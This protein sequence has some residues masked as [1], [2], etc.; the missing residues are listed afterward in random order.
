MNSLHCF[1]VSTGLRPERTH[2]LYK[3]FYFSEQDK[4]NFW[5]SVSG[6]YGVELLSQIKMKTI[7]KLTRGEQENGWGVD[8]IG[9]GSCSTLGRV[10]AM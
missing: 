2:S 9:S 8:A 1:E 4:S 6:A 7:K 5:C 10:L 3:F